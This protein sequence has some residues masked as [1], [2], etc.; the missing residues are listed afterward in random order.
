MDED[1]NDFDATQ[2]LD[3]EYGGQLEDT[4]IKKEVKYVFLLWHDL[5]FTSFTQYHTHTWTCT[6][7]YT[8]TPRRHAHTHTP[9]R[10]AHTH[11]ADMHTHTYNTQTCTH[12]HTTRRHAHTHTHTPR[13]HAHTHTH[14]ADMLM[15]FS[16]K[17]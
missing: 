6:H 16:L 11:H 17:S 13:R 15:C 12:T 8:H 10:H 9:H 2:L 7:M 4:D 1:D 5:K 3:M 14:H